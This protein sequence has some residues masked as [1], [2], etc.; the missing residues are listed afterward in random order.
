MQS[1][2]ADDVH[3]RLDH[4]MQQKGQTNVPAVCQLM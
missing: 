1:F 4:S 2:R 3:L